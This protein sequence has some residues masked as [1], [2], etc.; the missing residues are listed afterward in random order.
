MRALAAVRSSQ[1]E[2]EARRRTIG[3]LLLFLLAAGLAVASASGLLDA[4]PSPGRWWMQG[5]R[6]YQSVPLVT[7]SIHAPLTAIR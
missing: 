2:S 1:M 3:L 6:T 5:Y 4:E 7:N